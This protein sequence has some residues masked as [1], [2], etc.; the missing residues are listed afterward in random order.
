MAPL[1]VRV[2]GTRAALG[3]RTLQR[4][5]AEAVGE[6][7]FLL[8]APL[9][10]QGRLGY[11]TNRAEDYLLGSVQRIQSDTAALQAGA[12]C[13]VNPATTPRPRQ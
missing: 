10:V 7:A 2:L 8:N 1:V 11:R 12:S 9:T 6:Q 5:V 4:L 3:P 13:R